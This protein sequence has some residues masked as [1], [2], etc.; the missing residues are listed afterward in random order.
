M[1]DSKKATV[2]TGDKGCIVMVDLTH[3]MSQRDHLVRLCGGAISINALI[4]LGHGQ[5]L[6][7]V[8]LGFQYPIRIDA[9]IL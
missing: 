8:R 4:H 5:T 1:A 6:E 7:V 9:A 3:L 2:K